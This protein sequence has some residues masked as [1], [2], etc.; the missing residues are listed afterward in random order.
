MSIVSQRL[1]TQSV[2]K[3][4]FQYLLPSLLGM[5]LMSVNIMIDGIFVGNGVGSTALAGVNVAVPVFSIVIS[6]ALLIGIGGG[7]LY[8]MAVGRGDFPAAQ[9]IFS[10]SFVLVVLITVVICLFSYLNIERLGYIFGANEETI[11]YVIDYMKVLLLFSLVISVETWLSIFI[12]NDG[13]PQL[14]MIGLSA[15]A[16]INIGLNYWMI[17][18][19]KLG[20]TGAAYATI[21][22]TFIGLLILATHFLKKG[23]HLKFVRPRWEGIMVKR[24]G[25]IG[26]PSFLSEMGIG[27]F[28]IG[29]NIAMSHHVGTEGLAAFS[30]IN[31]LHAFT[32]LAFIGVGSSIQPMISYYYG[33]KKY[34]MI[35]DTVKIAERSAFLIGLLFLVIGYLGAEQLVSIFGISSESIMSYSVS[36]I[37]LFFIGYLFMGI[38]FIYMTYYQ[39]IGYIRPSLWIIIFKGFIL[40]MIMLLILPYMMGIAGIWLSLP[41]AEAIVAII[42]LIFVRKKVIQQPIKEPLP[43]QGTNRMRSDELV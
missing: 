42:L 18:I 19:L 12:R 33:A 36:G 43:T 17:F 26:F 21:I 24:I 9:R 11:P 16:V 8:S 32:F 37:K 6:I 3:S 7:T 22:A 31:Y 5:M 39:S 30:V 34:D 1:G 13:N 14:A 41:V 35:K 10:I 40:L 15:S 38:N 25:S 28:V 23:S 2:T 29:Y 4:F 27:I 20:V